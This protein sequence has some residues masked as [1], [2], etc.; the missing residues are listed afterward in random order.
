MFPLTISLGSRL[1]PFYEGLY[2]MISFLVAGIWA[3][4]RWR[5]AGLP[6]RALETF[7]LL[8][9]LGAILGARLSHFIFWNPGVLL[10]DPLEFFRFWQGGLSVSGGIAF[11]ALGGYLASRI[12]KVDF[13]TVAAAT[14]P[15]VLLG[16]AVGRIG[17]FLNGDAFGAPSNLPWAVAFPR[18]ALRLPS[19][20]TDRSLSSFAW[21]WCSERGLVGPESAFS[22]PM[23]PTQLYEAAL[24]LI[25]LGLI[26]L[27]QRKKPGAQGG[28]LSLLG[29]LGGYSVIRFSLEFLRADHD[30]TAL[31]GMTVFQLVLLATALACAALAF[32][33]GKA[34]PAPAKASGKPA[35]QGKG[36]AKGRRR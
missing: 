18:Y 14:A 33:P 29:L 7:F 36:K 21:E 28:R 1:M 35:A 32:L 3:A 12:A 10:G 13:P 20:R 27:L 5:R 4:R 11:G 24:D 9:A 2:F 6:D 30:G 17:C 15:A 19:F 22:L 31:L 25:L 8:V 16:Q 34:A 26:L 23:H